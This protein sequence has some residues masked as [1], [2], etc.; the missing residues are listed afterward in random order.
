MQG[1]SIVESVWVGRVIKEDKLLFVR[2]GTVV[3]KEVDGVFL[4]P[5]V[6]ECVDLEV[7]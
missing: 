5:S 4:Y 6:L 2:T 1:I 7:G 3:L